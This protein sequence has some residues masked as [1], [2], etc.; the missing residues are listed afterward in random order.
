V[1]KRGDELAEQE[2][3]RERERGRARE[4]AD[5]RKKLHLELEAMRTERDSYE[6]A[7]RDA[8]A[9]LS[10]NGEPGQRVAELSARL[11][12]FE[13]GVHLEEQR[14]AGIEELLEAATGLSQ[15][16]ADPVP[17]EARVAE[18]QHLLEAREQELQ[19][20]LLEMD[21]VHSGETDA[22]DGRAAEL[23]DKEAEVLVLHSKIAATRRRAAK[24][25]EEI[26]GY[27]GRVDTLSAEEIAGLLDEL[28]ADVEELEK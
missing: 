18:L 4:L 3:E 19:E 28:S 16:L 13:A 6:R 1:Q 26:A 20:Q 23:S 12:A 8:E 17:L 21:R 10:K 11:Q 22:R 2:R 14:L 5:E 24:L 15:R 27:R 25:R 7:L 9:N